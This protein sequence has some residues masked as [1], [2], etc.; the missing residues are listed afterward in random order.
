[1]N[2]YENNDEFENNSSNIKDNFED[3]VKSV[4]HGG[5]IMF[6]DAGIC[7]VN[8]NSKEFRLIARTNDW[9]N[10]ENEI[11]P[12]V[13]DINY[14]FLIDEEVCYSFE[15]S[16][17]YLLKN[18]TNHNAD[19]FIEC[20]MNLYGLSEEEVNSYIEK[21]NIVLPINP[22]C[23]KGTR[24]DKSCEFDFSI[25]DRFYPK[26]NKIT[27]EDIY[28]V[29]ILFRCVYDLKEVQDKFSLAT[30]KLQLIVERDNLISAYKLM[31]SKENVKIKLI[32]CELKNDQID[33]E[34]TL[35]IFL[36]KDGKNLFINHFNINFVLSFEKFKKAV[37]NVYID[38]D[39]T[40]EEDEE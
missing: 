37:K 35:T 18:Y 12:I 7:Q 13:E 26:S 38:I 19:G 24:L 11:I 6:P 8:K 36:N 14:D 10:Y 5:Y 39:E 31:N 21:N 17:D 20:S 32:G 1:M 15:E 28:Q 3:R 27:K 40:N 25:L 29:S 2:E 33:E 23:V 16:F 34:E 9:D 30:E 22:S 4:L